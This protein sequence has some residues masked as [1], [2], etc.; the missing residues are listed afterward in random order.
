MCSLVE[1]IHNKHRE[2]KGQKKTKENLK[3]VRAVLESATTGVPN[4]RA[5]DQY[6]PTPF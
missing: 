6:R 2:T 3:E 1:N 4:L 5:V